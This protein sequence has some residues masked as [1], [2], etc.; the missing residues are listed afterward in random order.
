ML[1]PGPRHLARRA[2][3]AATVTSAI[4]LPLALAGPASADQPRQRQ[5]WVLNALD[6]PAAWTTT[7]GQ[8]VTVAVIDSGVDPTVSDLTG[9]V[10]AGPDYTGVHT[11][12]S[13]PNWGVHGTWMASLIAGHGN[14][15]GD[16]NGIL[17]VA[18]KAHILSVRV[19]TDRTDPGYAA[20]QAE[21]AWRGQR[22]LA[23][24]IKY[25]V[26]HHAAVISMS[27]G[28]DAPS[29]AVRAAM[30]Y[31][32]RRNVV[33]V[34]S[35][36]NSG[37][38]HSPQQRGAAPYSFPADY[39]GVIGVAAVNQAGQPAYFS[40]ENLSV[41]IAAPGVNVPAQGRDSKYW[42]VSGTSPACALAAGVAA[43]VRSKYPKLSAAQV[44]EAIIGSS[45][46]RPKGGYDDHVGFGTVDA[47]A[48]LRAASRLGGQ[49]PA[50]Q[51]QAGRRAASGNFGGGESRVAAFPVPPQGRN[52][53]YLLLGLGAVSLLVLI[54]AL[55]WLARR[56]GRGASAGRTVGPGT[57]GPVP[58]PGH[59]ADAGP[60]AADVRY[61][62]QIFPAQ[63]FRQGRPAPGT[64]GQ[65]VQGFPGPGYP[66]PG[67]PGP[68]F[69]GPGYPGPGYPG[70]GFP[71]PGYPE[72]G[73]QGEGRPGAGQPAPGYAGADGPGA[74]WPGAGYPGD[75]GYPGAGYQGAGPAAGYPGGGSVP[76]G[77]AA[78][79]PEPWGQPDDGK[80]PQLPPG[81]VLPGLSGPT[82]VAP[83]AA[84]DGTPPRPAQPDAGQ[85]GPAQPAPALIDFR[86]GGVPVAGRSVSAP[87]ASGDSDDWAF[88][89][90]D[91]TGT[92]AA[93]VPRGPE[94]P[95]ASS[96]RPAAPVALAPE[97]PPPS[98]PPRSTRP[99]TPPSTPPRSTRPS[100]S[101]ADRGQPQS[102]LDRWLADPLTSPRIPDSVLRGPDS[103][104][105]T[106]LGESLGRTDVTR[107]FRSPGARPR[108]PADSRANDL[109]PERPAAAGLS[110]GGA[111]AGPADSP[112]S[113][114]PVPAGAPDAPWPGPSGL[115]RRTPGAQGMGPADRAA[116]DQAGRPDHDQAQAGP[117]GPAQAG[118]AGPA[119]AGPAG[120]AQAGPAGPAQAGQGAGPPASPAR[121]VFEPL[122]RTPAGQDQQVP[123]SPGED[124]RARLSQ[125]IATVRRWDPAEGDPAEGDPAEGDPAS[126][127]PGQEA[128]LASPA[129]AVADAAAT[130]NGA[131]DTAGWGRRAGNGGAPAHGARDVSGVTSPADAGT[132][133]G[134]GGAPGANAGAASAAGAAGSA[135]SAGAAAGSA[136]RAAGTRPVTRAPAG[137]DPAPAGADH[138]PVADRGPGV[139]DRGTSGTDRGASGT[140][141]PPGA[142]AESSR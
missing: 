45:A 104:R 63:P 99:S 32:L 75:V 3:A 84:Q 24:A 74:G 87:S 81:Q 133:G 46:H 30:Q 6:V 37:T 113:R 4:V 142:S 56:R 5:Q 136:A 76:P 14:G 39:P 17:G 141:G 40:S 107:P 95:P 98:M 59:G 109:P 67:F 38:T 71:G 85:A 125:Q 96:S 57:P 50:G 21:P 103:W 108:Q 110:G 94:P 27:L 20:Y 127:T 43:L 64:V 31:A 15:P 124:W 42:E 18:P 35:S 54:L 89:Q 7:Q 1:T 19:I 115:P 101:P 123:G 49:V 66:G 62:T 8:G 100:T 36:G 78:V 12:S 90:D 53:I 13:N 82:A 86:P 60:P 106:R 116:P 91:P 80:Q 97:T 51:T 137:A 79:P 102:D 105:A 134:A 28:Y 10:T 117:A 128:S 69:P 9:Q 138:G 48:A 130:P 119:Q 70:P 22:E 92:P 83:E 112:A 29:S 68:G 93:D 16:R 2:A 65:A 23:D 26:R 114:G 118:P 73:Y 139:A 52:R 72:S 135:R 122:H 61:P 55:W 111:G 140:G 132:A 129:G 33:V 25:S 11:P 131:A 77:V 34:A 47:A 58:G 88:E 120:P 44:R 121:S 41:E 126:A